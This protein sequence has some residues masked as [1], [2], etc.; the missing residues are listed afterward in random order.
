MKNTLSSLSLKVA[1]SAALLSLGACSSPPTRQQLGVASGAV[2]GGVA[3]HA[4][5][6]G[7]LGTVGGAAAGALVGNEMTKDGRRR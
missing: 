4:L 5:F 3:G 6:G 2:L 7:P 1:L